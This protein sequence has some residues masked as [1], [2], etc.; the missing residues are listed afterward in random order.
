LVLLADLVSKHFVIG[1][2]WRGEYIGGLFR[3]TLTHNPGAAFGLFPGAHGVFIAIK[4]VALTIIL[5]LLGRGKLG[6]GA[7]LTLPLALIFGGAAG[8][9][10]DRLRNG[11]EVIDFIDLGLGASRWYIFNVADACITVGAAFVVLA[12]LRDGSRAEAA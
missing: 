8:N 12:L 5:V 1:G 2:A 11:G 4:L 3:I 9:L 7:Y 10:I 6:L